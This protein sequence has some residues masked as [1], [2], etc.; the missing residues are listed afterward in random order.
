MATNLERTDGEYRWALD[1]DVM[2]E[3][4]DDYFATDLWAVIE[5][6]PAGLEIHVVRA[7]R[8]S[9]LSD[10]A[11]ARIEAAARRTGRVFAHRVEGGHWLNADNPDAV[12][13]LLEAHLPGAG[14]PA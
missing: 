14:A 12:V 1:F 2:R 11:A 5:A 9:V 7:S 3:L 4:L 13:S 10:E 6:P 8:S